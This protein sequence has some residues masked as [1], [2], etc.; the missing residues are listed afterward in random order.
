MRIGV[1]LGAT[2]VRA[3]VVDGGIIHKIVSDPFPYDKSEQETIDS[4]INTI[5]KVM[6]SNIKGI[7]IGVPSIV[8]ARHGIVYNTINI[9]SWKEIFLKE[10][11]ESEFQVQVVVNNDS[12]CFVFGERYYG[13]ATMYQNIVGVILGAGV[14][15]GIIVNNMLYEGMNTGAGE[16]GSLSYLDSDYES[17]CS[18]HFFQRF[19]TTG[20]VL[21]LRA[22]NNDPE[23]LR[24]WEE[25]GFHVGNLLKAVLS[26]YDPEAIVIGGNIA[27]AFNYFAKTMYQQLDTFL[28]PHIIK[29]V[30]ILVSRKEN[31]GLLG[32]A[33]LIP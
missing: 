17:Y 12:N 21:L 7:G 27:P 20:H 11:L 15:A 2:N 28:H 29:S 26:V 13:E 24:I 30:E 4:L 31:I 23:A 18:A 33:A 5:R 8:D 32:A 22:N 16:I 9:P 1:D 14:G 10:I 6:N 25:F 19:N 3:G